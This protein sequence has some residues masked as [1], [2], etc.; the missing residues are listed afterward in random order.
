[1]ALC[2]EKQRCFSES[3]NA[4]KIAEYP[5]VK[6]V[7]YADVPRH[8][9]RALHFSQ[10]AGSVLSFLTGSLALSKHIVESTK[11]FSI[12]VSFVDAFPW[13]GS[14]KSLVSMRCFMSHA[15]IPAAVREARGLMEDLIRISVGIEDVNDLIADSDHA[16]ARGPV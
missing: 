4:Q 7:N 15:S 10:G 13:A 12:T 2:V 16:L 9:L 5:R 11:Y 8:P 14:V 1:M 3:E 6:K